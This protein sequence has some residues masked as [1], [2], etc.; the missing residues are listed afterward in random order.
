[1]PQFF[2]SLCCL[3]IDPKGLIAKKVQY[4]SVPWK[5]IVGFGIRTAGK[6]LEFDMRGEFIPGR[7][8]SGEDNPPVP[9]EP[10]VSYLLVNVG[11]V[12]VYYYFVVA[13]HF[14][15]SA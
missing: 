8:C 3:I 11:Y 12:T 1:M 14:S 10:Y 6:Y 15:H 5:S 7:A 13:R 4:T 9:P 2:Q